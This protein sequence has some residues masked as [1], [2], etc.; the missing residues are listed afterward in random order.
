MRLF[1]G[2]SIQNMMSTLGIE[3]DVP[4]ENKMVTNA[5]ENAQRKVEGRNFGYARTCCST[6]TL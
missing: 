1:G 6:T 4:I 5:I 2:D 3:D